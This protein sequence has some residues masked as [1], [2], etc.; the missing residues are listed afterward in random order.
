MILLLLLGTGKSTI[1]THVVKNFYDA[2]DVGVLSNNI[3]R[4]FGI[5]AFYDKYIFIGPECRNDLAIE[6]AEFQSIVSGEDIQVNM[7]HK[8]AFSV[9]W[10]VPGILAGNEVPSWADAAGSIQRRLPVFDFEKPV[11]NGDMRLGQ[12]IEDELPDL[13][14]KCNRAY[15]EKANQ[16]GSANIWSLLPA[17]FQR[18]SNELA[19][20]IN[21]LEAFLACDEV[22]FGP[23]CAVPFD[24]F[25][26]SVVAY[27]QINGY[28]RPKF[29]I[30]YF[31][32]P[33]TRRRI[34]KE[35]CTRTWRGR[36]LHRDF[37]LG[38]DLAMTDGGGAG[39]VLG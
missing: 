14:V 4:K 8:K 19:Q 37:L 9:K 18:T 31:R 3:E 17:Y 29:S 21:A 5:S 16:H 30:D 33:F 34:Q 23:E 36:V 28:A 10:H 26:N 6:Q 20:T 35:K 11:V 1:C 7:K 25:K 32:G 39:N 2:I 27:A 15:R 12:K 22:S 13:I 24:E 38:V